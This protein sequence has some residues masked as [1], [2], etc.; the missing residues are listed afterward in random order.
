MRN[1]RLVSRELPTLIVQT[2]SVIFLPFAKAVK[3][4]FRRYF[5]WRW[6]R[7]KEWIEYIKV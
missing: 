5:H 7:E 2:W 3:V 6:R 4:N 1:E